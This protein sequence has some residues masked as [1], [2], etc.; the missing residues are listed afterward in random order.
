MMHFASRV[1]LTIS[2]HKQ[3]DKWDTFLSNDGCSYY[4]K[5]KDGASKKVALNYFAI[6]DAR[7]LLKTK[8]VNRKHTTLVVRKQY[9]K[10][11]I[12]NDIDI[13]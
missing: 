10:R 4:L 13:N 11:R 9:I 1:W 3:V 7:I 12:R 5:L 6:F 2:V 8:K